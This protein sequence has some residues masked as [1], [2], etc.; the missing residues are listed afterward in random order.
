MTLSLDSQIT[1]LYTRDLA[2]TTRFYEQ[3]LGLRLI[4]DQG[5]CRIYRITDSAC[6]GFCQRENLPDQ[7]GLE[8]KVIFTL[9]TQDVDGWYERLTSQGIVIEKPPVRDPAYDIYHFFLRDPNGYLIEIQ[10][11]L[12]SSWSGQA[13]DAD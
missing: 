8:S 9:V 6:L 7:P 12:D 4:L 11:F 3:A 13:S 5:S 10:R 2:S 1:F